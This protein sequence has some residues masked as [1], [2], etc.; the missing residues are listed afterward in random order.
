MII[1]G[2]RSLLFILILRTCVYLGAGPESLQVQSLL[3][4]ALLF[5]VTFAKQ[6]IYKPRVMVCFD[7][8]FL[9]K[10]QTYSGAEKSA[11]PFTIHPKQA[12]IHHP[13]FTRVL[14]DDET[15]L[16]A[17]E[18]REPLTLRSDNRSYMFAVTV[19]QSCTS[20][21]QPPYRTS[22]APWP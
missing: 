8:F 2:S 12:L 1:S 14:K 3:R 21:P 6:W 18:V 20:A 19:D 17:A 10:P 15:H 16:R 5:S 13:T 7:L 22:S 11:K 9:G 4:S